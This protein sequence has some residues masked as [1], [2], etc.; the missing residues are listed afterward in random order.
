MSLAWGVEWA[1]LGGFTSLAT[2]ITVLNILMLFA[3]GKNTFL[4]Y[5][6]HYVVLAVALRNIGR[7]AFSSLLILLAKLIENPKDLQSLVTLSDFDENTDLSQAQEMPLT[8]DI[9]SMIDHILMTVLMFYLTA[10]SLYVFCRQPNPPVLSSSLKTLKLYG[11]TSSIVP[12]RETWWVTT[13]LVLLPPIMAVLL[14]LP[15]LLLHIPHTLAAIPGGSVCVVSEKIDSTT[16]E[17]SVAILGFC[18][19]VAIILCL[20]IGLSIRRCV[21]CSGGVCVSSFCKEELVM[22]LLTLSYIFGYLTLYLPLLDHHLALLELPSTNLQTMIT[23]EIART[24]EM[25]QGLL[26]PLYVFILLPMYRQFSSDPDP[27]DQRRSK[28]DQSTNAPDSRR[29]SLAS[30]GFD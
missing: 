15:V 13:I 2:L 9:L 5:S 18:L 23:P 10:L 19:P 3:V 16:Y 11:L 17:S 29:A 6:F 30:F 4:H 12:V 14:S 25:A 24:V 21:S 28:R 22:T 7:V 1:W 20:I 27:S 26:L 8:C